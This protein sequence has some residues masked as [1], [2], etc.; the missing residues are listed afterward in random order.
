M[1]I[2]GSGRRRDRPACLGVVLLAALLALTATPTV[3][4]QGEATGGGQG[5]GVLLRL[6]HASPDAGDVDVYVDGLRAARGVRFGGFSNLLPLEAG[7]HWIGLVPADGDVAEPAVE[8]EVSLDANAVYELA[9]VGLVAT[10]ALA[11]D[12]HSVD[13]GPLREEH[14]RVRLVQA[15]PDARAVDLRL[16]DRVLL[17]DAAFRQ[18]TGYRV[19]H[20]G[21]HEFGLASRNN[22]TPLLAVP[23]TDIGAGLAYS[24][25]AVGL[26]ADGSLAIVPVPTPADGR[27]LARIYRGG[28]GDAGAE[29]RYDLTAFAAPDDTAAQVAPAVESSVTPLQATLGEILLS[30]HSLWVEREDAQGRTVLACGEIGGAPLPGDGALVVGLREEGG[31]GTAG[32]AYVAPDPASG[33]MVVS[34]FVGGGI[35]TGGAPPRP[36]APTAPRL[37]GIHAGTCDAFD[38]VPIVDLGRIDAPAGQVLGTV[39]TAPVKVSTSTLPLGLAALAAEDHALVVRLAGGDGRTVLAC[40]EIVGV[41]QADGALVVALRERDGSGCVGVVYLAPQPGG[42]LAVSI[43]AVEDARSAPAD[44]ASEGEAT[45]GADSGSAG[46]RRAA[47]DG[48]GAAGTGGTEQAAAS[49]SSA[50]SGGTGGSTSGADQPPSGGTTGPAA[51]GSTQP[52][53]GGSAAPPAGSTGG[54]GPAQPAPA[55]APAAPAPP[56]TGSVPAAP[57]EPAPVPPAPIQTNPVPT[58]PGTGA[59]PA[60][61]AP[62]GLAP[63]G[64]APVQTA[65]VP[66]VPPPSVPPPPVQTAPVTGAVPVQSPPVESVT[67]PVDAA[68]DELGL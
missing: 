37:V 41:R 27:R 63:A 21:P 38:P 30:I 7:V 36:V 13:V 53:S 64:P 57:T 5:T 4:A 12:L 52:S 48:G 43:F 50:P 19:L 42:Q 20:T 44:S 32:V 22:R 17:P 33:G 9:A 54:S 18:A 66:S 14:A 67:A 11:L 56:Q 8:A 2:V 65:P 58:A 62:T 28:C 46:D 6:V 23:K 45:S 55:F 31:S 61:P 51:G 26:V 24:L 60:A 29:P 49:G 1:E 25:Y 47:T 16:A 68:V 40:G 15:S 10:G 59:V 35:T 3:F 34:V 39:S